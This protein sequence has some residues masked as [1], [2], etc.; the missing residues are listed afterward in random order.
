MPNGKLVV[1]EGADAVGKKT[2]SRLLMAELMSGGK[3][4]DVLSFPRYENF[5]G[6]LI[7]EALDG[8]LG[9]FRHL[10]PKLASLPYILDR[11]HSREDV[12]RALVENDVV[13]CNRY[14]ESN[15]AYAMARVLFPEDRLE[16]MKW[17]YQAEYDELGFI[18][19]A[20][21]VILL[22]TVH[23]A[24]GGLVW[25]RGEKLDQHEA[26]EDFQK[27]VMDCY[28]ALARTFPDAWRVVRCND[29][30]QMRTPQEISC[31]VLKAVREV[32]A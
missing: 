18:P 8:D 23:A 21:L 15:V 2:Q 13:I 4:V 31:D 3:K 19:Q 5:F 9:D 1:I 16:I 29:G 12:V 32:L 17:L 20:D 10:H 14:M 27:D 25:K 28:R 30:I 24:S 22:D 11:I 6:K 7:R 26:D